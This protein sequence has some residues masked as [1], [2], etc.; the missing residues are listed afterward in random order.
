L[1]RNSPE[2]RNQWINENIIRDIEERR[3]YK[4]AKDNHGI[5]DIKS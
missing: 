1:K 2:P 4:N 5:Q 3:K